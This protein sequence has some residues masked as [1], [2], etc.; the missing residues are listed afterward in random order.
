MNLRNIPLVALRFAQAL[1]FFSATPANKAEHIFNDIIPNL[2][3]CFIQ[4]FELVP[5]Q[6]RH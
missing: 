6:R 2:T 4:P 3:D 1:A 5:S